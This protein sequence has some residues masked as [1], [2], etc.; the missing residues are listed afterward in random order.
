MATFNGD[1]DLE[2]LEQKRQKLKEMAKIILEGGS[3]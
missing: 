2:Y 1:V 3:K